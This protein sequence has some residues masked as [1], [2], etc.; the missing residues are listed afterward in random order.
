MLEAEKENNSSSKIVNS[1][2]RRA[3]KQ[4]PDLKEEIS[5][6][7]FKADYIFKHIY[8]STFTTSF[9]LTVIKEKETMP[10]HY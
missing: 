6:L 7:W 4:W 2:E 8:T 3:T 10:L 9:L 1:K 5:S